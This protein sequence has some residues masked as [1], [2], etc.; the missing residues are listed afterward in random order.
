MNKFVTDPDPD[1]GENDTDPDPAKKDQV[2][3]K[4]FIS[5][6]KCSYPMFCGCILLNNHLSINTGNQFN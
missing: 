1:S 6:E 4:L 5:D 2:P 3:E